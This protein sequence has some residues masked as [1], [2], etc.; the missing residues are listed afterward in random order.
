MK[1]WPLLAL[2]LVG[3]LLYGGCS[4]R[5]QQSTQ[6]PVDVTFSWTNPSQYVDGTLI[7]T[8]DLTQVRIEC[9][10]NNNTVA[11]LIETFPVVNGEGAPQ[12]GTVTGGIPSPGTYACVGYAILFNGV[13]SDASNTTVKKF[14]GKPNA[15]VNLTF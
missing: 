10:R 3:A 12:S 7:D 2:L 11:S 8:G 6:F 14:T 15:P 5:A 13:E 9:F 1:T 4:A